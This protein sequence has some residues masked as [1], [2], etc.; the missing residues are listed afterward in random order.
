MLKG[1]ECTVRGFWSKYELTRDGSYCG[2]S[3]DWRQAAI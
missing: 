3:A 1:L 2:T